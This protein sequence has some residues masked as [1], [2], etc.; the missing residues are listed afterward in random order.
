MHRILK[1]YK[2]TGEFKLPMKPKPKTKTII[3]ETEEMIKNSIRRKVHLFYLIPT[4]N[5]IL[6]ADDFKR[7]N[8]WDLNSRKGIEI[9]AYKSK[10]LR[11]GSGD[12]SD[13]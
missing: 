5:K 4:L 7:T 6:S 11:Y 9:E 2:G 10:K 12:I 13:K 8:M 3:K 1:E